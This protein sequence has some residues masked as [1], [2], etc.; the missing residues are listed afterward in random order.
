MIVNKTFA[1]SYKHYLNIF[2]SQPPYHE[3]NKYFITIRNLPE[4]KLIIYYQTEA[5]I[6][7]EKLDDIFKSY[8]LFLFQAQSWKK[9]QS[10]NYFYLT[11][12]IVGILSYFILH[13]G[14][15]SYN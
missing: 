7:Y 14:P 13:W 1:T 6:L 4:K 15:Y 12:S 10:S 9:Q 3:Y 11:L 5:K 8:N 2:L